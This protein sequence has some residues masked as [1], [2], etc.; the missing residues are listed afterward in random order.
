ME[1]GLIG[2]KLGHSFSVE[3][4]KK[5]ARYDY[6]LHPIAPEALDRFLKEKAFC[7]I[8][9]TIPY[10]KEVMGYLDEISPD[11]TLCGAVNT[12]ICRNGRLSGYNT[13]ILGMEDCLR[14][15][16]IPIQNKTVAILGTGGTGG[17]ALALC[18][19][20]GAE[21]ILRVSRTKK[22]GCVTYEELAEEKGVQVILNTTP[23]G[24]Y[25]DVASSPVD[26][27]LFP[28]L[29]AVADVVYNPLKTRLVLQAESLGLPAAG[30]LR[31]LVAQAVYAA[32]LF[33]GEE[34]LVDRIEPIYRRILEEKKNLV[35]IGM[36]GSGKSTLGKILAQRL[37][38]DF[39]DSDEEIVKEEKKTIPEIFSEGGEGL[40]RRIEARVI[41]R[42]A[43]CQGKVIAT[44]G[45]AI[46]DPEN[47]A[48]LKAN[49]TLLFLDAPVETLVGT[50]DRPLARDAEAMKRRYE[51]RYELY[52]AAAEKRVLVSRNVEENIRKIEK[53]LQ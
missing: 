43:A 30:G 38:K 22:E 46:L 12:V 19:K 32:A 52:C 2:E 39:A 34:A 26:L 25:P 5:I 35:L 15:G 13:D 44:G 18:R 47:V 50:A 1:Y 20:L 45:G 16:G 10:K 7:G 49:G 6:V 21:R 41:A 14:A 31:M 40:F 28:R 53:E 24:M 36:P 3:I 29:E 27:T 37:G 11:A 33:T 8:N 23:S 9:V 51:E 4:H 48:A 42:L 17:T